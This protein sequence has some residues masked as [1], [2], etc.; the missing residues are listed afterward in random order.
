MLNKSG[1]SGHPCLIPDFRGNG[2]S[3]FPFSMIFTI[4]LSY[5]DFVM[6][7]HIPSIPTFIKKGCWILSKVF[8]HLLRRSCG[9]CPCLCL[10][11]ALHLLIWVSLEWNWFDHGVWS[12]WY[13]VEFSFKYFISEFWE[14]LLLARL[15][16]NFCPLSWGY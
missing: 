12:F 6:L 2:F 9:F 16:C 15:L 13:F 8:L 5:I 11:A 3:F 10:Y 7:R 1:K 14:D 4:G